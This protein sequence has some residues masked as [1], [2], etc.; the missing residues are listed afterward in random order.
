MQTTHR[1]PLLTIHTEGSPLPPDLLQCVQS[2][3][4]II[5]ARYQVEPQLSPDALEVYEYLPKV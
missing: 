1:S 2:V 3:S 4:K 5:I